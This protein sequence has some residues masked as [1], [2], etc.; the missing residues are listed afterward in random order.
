MSKMTSKVFYKDG[1]TSNVLDHNK[2]I[3]RV[4]G[5]AIILYSKKGKIISK[6]WYIN[7]IEYTEEEFDLIISRGD[8]E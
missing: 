8:N 7:D 4:D 6:S 1:T 5:P 2:I 3:H